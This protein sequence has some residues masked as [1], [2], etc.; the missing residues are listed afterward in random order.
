MPKG[1]N[2]KLKLYHLSHIMTK[3]TDDDH[4][5]TLP[6]IQEQLKDYEV[7]ADRK[8]LY[9]DLE[10]LKVLGIDVVGKK[11][12]RNY[13]YH[14]VKKHFDIEELKIML[15][16]IQSSEHISKARSKKLTRKIMAMASDYE[17]KTLKKG[18]KA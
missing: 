2:Q 9:D 17:A 16:A 13:K 8:T 6:Q 3:K 12:G 14:V 7:D 11:V 5:L 1:R 4:W 15:D 10:T 18:M